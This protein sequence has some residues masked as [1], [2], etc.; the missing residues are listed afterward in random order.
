MQFKK[1]FN[2]SKCNVGGVS[3]VGVPF[4]YVIVC[5]KERAASQE[6][7]KQNNNKQKKN[8]NKQKKQ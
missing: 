6:V 8:N 5:M 2:L 7:V 3:V 1:Q 4:K